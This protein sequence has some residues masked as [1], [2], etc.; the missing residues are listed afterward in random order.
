MNHGRDL[1]VTLGQRHRHERRRLIDQ[2][3][4]EHVNVLLKL[5]VTQAVQ[6]LT[7]D[8][9]I[10][11]LTA[12]ASGNRIDE[13]LHQLELRQTKRCRGLRRPLRLSPLRA[14]QPVRPGEVPGRGRI[15]VVGGKFAH[16]NATAKA[17]HNGQYN[18]RA[19]VG[20]GGSVLMATTSHA[21]IL[22][23]ERPKTAFIRA[24]DAVF[25]D[26]VPAQH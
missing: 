4:G 21:L 3:A 11:V 14:V 9:L 13:L 2:N 10:D 7:R 20:Y 16:R 25:C 12:A 1:L 19:A 5:L 18:G 26:C 17:K 6:L 24:P 23:Y 15:T 8:G 22:P